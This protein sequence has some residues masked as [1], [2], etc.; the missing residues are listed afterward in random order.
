M[1]SKSFSG[2]MDNGCYYNILSTQYGRLMMK[3]RSFLF[4]AVLLATGPTVAGAYSQAD[5]D[6]L[7]AE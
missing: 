5:V 3:W 4:M 6:R 7:L 2:T 1:Q